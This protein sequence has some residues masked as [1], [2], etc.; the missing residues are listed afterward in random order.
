MAGL[1]LRAGQ[2]GLSADFPGIDD[3]AGV[4][5]GGDRAR[6]P[7]SEGSGGGRRCRVRP[8][9]FPENKPFTPA[10]KYFV[11]FCRQPTPSPLEIEFS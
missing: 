10:K 6:I 3:P 1:R 7:F 2:A 8:E 4:L 5:N 9:N 11:R